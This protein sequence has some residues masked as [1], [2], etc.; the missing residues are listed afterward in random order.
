M[1]QVPLCALNA[2]LLSVSPQWHGGGKSVCSELCRLGFPGRL[3]EAPYQE[4]GPEDP[5]GS[6]ARV[7]A[8]SS[9]TQGPTFP[10]FPSAPVLPFQEG[11][12][13]LP[14]PLR[15]PYS[16]LLILQKRES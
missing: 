4:D 5:E 9:S 14:S 7:F 11:N 1:R 13:I 2:C 6:F 12:F 8:R 3:A 15:P 10:A 16:L